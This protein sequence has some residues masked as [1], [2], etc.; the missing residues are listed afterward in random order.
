M[1][2][3]FKETI[4]I[5]LVATPADPKNAEGGIVTMVTWFAATLNGMGAKLASA[6][7]TV[8]D[9]LTVE[10]MYKLIKLPPSL[11]LPSILAPLLW[12]IYAVQNSV[13]LLVVLCDRALK[14]QKN[15]ARAVIIIRI[16]I[17]TLLT[18]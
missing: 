8:P 6:M 4:C 9:V 2:T 12:S 17:F 13:P 7:V 14:A 18:G 5:P 3:G 15:T 10:V 11:P 1:A 16:N